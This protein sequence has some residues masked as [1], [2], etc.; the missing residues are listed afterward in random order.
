MRCT[1]YNL[2]K[3]FRL[4][5]ITKKFAADFKSKL[6]EDA[7]SF[8]STANGTYFFLFSY[9]V[10]VFWGFTEEQEQDL[11]KQ[12]LKGDHV[13]DVYEYTL[14]E[15]QNVHQDR[16]TLKLSSPKDLQMLA[17]S[18]GISQSMVL[19]SFEDRIYNTI[20]ETKVIPKHLAQHGK[21]PLS[22]REIAKKIG[23]VMME[24]NSV[25]LHTDILDVPP[26]IWD[27]PE[28]DDIYTKTI[29]DLD[30]ASRTEVLNTRLNILKDLFDVMSDTLNHRH[31]ALLEWIIIIL[32]FIE[33]L[34]SFW[35]HMLH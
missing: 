2:D 32:I 10:V 4:K 31:S 17:V 16:I 15:E 14:G 33:V 5:P 30:I 18:Y 21:I 28:Y 27:H 7:V 6:Y 9:G 22:R 24:R 1:G 12:I 26:F 13:G 35:T 23:W 11:L 8:E 34:F 3:D 29:M 20:E 19:H 25:N